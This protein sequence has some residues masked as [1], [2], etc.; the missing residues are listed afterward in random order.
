MKKVL[1]MVLSL[2]SAL[3]VAEAEI[4]DA[5]VRGLIP[6]RDMSAGFMSF[7]NT[8]DANIT[9]VSASSEAAGR[10]ELHTSIHEDGMMKMRKLDQLLVA[11]GETVVFAPG[12]HHLMLFN[13]DAQVFMGGHV[14][15][16]LFDSEGKSYMVHAAVQSAKNVHGNGHMHH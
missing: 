9:L 7:K 15:M 13:C 14:M 12:G 10:V 4:S 8:G 1:M 11:P 2:W 6:G 3:S 16:T 5:F